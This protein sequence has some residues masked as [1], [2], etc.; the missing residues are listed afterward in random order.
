MTIPFTVVVI[1]PSEYHFDLWF[2]PIIPA[3]QAAVGG[4]FSPI[5]GKH[6]QISAFSAYHSGDKPLNQL[7]KKMLSQLG[8]QLPMGLY[9]SVVIISQDM[10]PYRFKELIN[11]STGNGK[12]NARVPALHGRE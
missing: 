12:K 6:S 10:S 5:E 1:T 4:F 11:K 8:F 9:G 7:A 2:E 3:I